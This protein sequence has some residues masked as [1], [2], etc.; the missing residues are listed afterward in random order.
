MYVSA[1]VFKRVTP[2]RLSVIMREQT[3][4]QYI[5]LFL[6]LLIHHTLCFKTKLLPPRYK[7]ALKFL[8]YSTSA[9]LYSTK[10]E[11]ASSEQHTVSNSSLS[12]VYGYLLKQASSRKNRQSR[13][14]TI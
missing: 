10:L 14:R 13:F 4:S 1:I 9:L 6:L 7:K 3:L 8:I 2:W 12:S 11:R 5:P